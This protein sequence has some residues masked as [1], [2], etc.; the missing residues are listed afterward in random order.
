[1]INTEYNHQTNLFKHISQYDEQKTIDFIAID[2]NTNLPCAKWW[3]TFP[4]YG[5][6]EFNLP[7]E[8]IPQLSG[9]E[10]NAYCKGELISTSI[11]QWKKL[12]NRYQFSAPK[13]ELSFGSW[14]TLVYDNEYESKFNEDDVIYDL[15]ANFG[16]YTM[17]AVNNNVEQIYAFEPTPK[18]IFHLK[19]T[20]QFDNNV[21]IF[22]KAIGGEDKKITFY[23]QEHSVGNSMYADGGDALEVDCINLETFILSNNLKHP[24]I[25]KCDIE[26]SEYDFI[27]SLTDDFFKGIHTF[28][29]EFHHND[30]NQIWN[31]LKRLL[32][33][34]YNI[35]M[36]NNNKIDA[37]M[38]TFVARK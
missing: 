17:L 35:K 4:P 25:I 38:S 6:G 13:E 36:T 31:P 15:G 29:V 3:V 19:Q 18:N 20:F 8:Y 37:N 23:L 28:I 30:N 11:H 14:H 16:V 1:M 5:Y 27:E 12:D 21:T 10:L 7:V 2:L 24:T 33:L 34:G 32:N 26:G 9:I 22:D